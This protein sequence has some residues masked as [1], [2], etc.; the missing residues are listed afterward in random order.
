MIGV[1]RRRMMGNRATVVNPYISD[2]LIVWFDGIYKGQDVGVVWTD[3]IGGV[4]MVGAKYNTD[5]MQFEG[6]S[7]RALHQNIPAGL[8]YTVELVFNRTISPGPIFSC[9]SRAQNYICV[10]RYANNNF[11]FIQNQANWVID[12]TNRSTHVVSAN[13]SRCMQNG[14]EVT[15]AG[16]ANYYNEPE[17]VWSFFSRD[18]T[19]IIYCMRIYNRRLTLEEMLS[20][21][22]VDNNRFNL[23]LEL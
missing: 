15:T 6:S 9:G 23:G 14:V 17:N 2:G 4:Q 13:L 18:G 11:G 1:N 22:R 10:A 7:V 19:G 12:F 16:D 8:D 5:N 21:Q 3:L 20:N